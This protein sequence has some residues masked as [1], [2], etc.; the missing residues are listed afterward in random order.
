[1][2][3]STPPNAT[4]TAAER[5]RMRVDEDVAIVPANGDHYHLTHKGTILCGVSE[6]TTPSDRTTVATDTA[7]RRGYGLCDHCKAALPAQP[8]RDP[9]TDIDATGNPTCKQINL[10]KCNRAEALRLP[11][12]APGITMQGLKQRFEFDTISKFDNADIL[13]KRYDTRYDPRY[14][15]RGALWGADAN[16]HA[17]IDAN[18]DT[19]TTPCGRSTGVR[20]IEAGEV[21]SCTAADAVCD[22]RFDRATA[23]EVLE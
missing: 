1:M 13:V 14:E 9:P 4:A 22:C 8:R 12:P 21:F 2:S 15:G 17:W 23:E 16:C 20:T 3:K 5:R 10:L 7:T 6:Q 19:T 18:I 11:D